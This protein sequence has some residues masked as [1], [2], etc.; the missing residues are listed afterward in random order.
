MKRILYLSFYFEPDLCAG[1]FRNSP[2]LKELALQTEGEAT[3]DVITTLP[4]RYSS[5]Q[6]DAT[7]FESVQNYTVRRIAIPQHQS[8]MKDQVLAFRHYY[9]K[10]HEFVKG[11]SYDLVFASSSRLFTAYLGYTI[12]KSRNIPLYLDIRDIFTDT[13]NDVLKNKFLKA[14]VLPVLKQIEKRVFQYASHINLISGGFKGYFE[15]YQGPA[16]SNFP[17]GIDEIFLNLPPSTVRHPGKK[18]IVYAGNFGE[19]QGLHIIVPQAAKRLES[20]YEFLLIGDG[21]AKDRLLKELT[22]LHVQN[23]NVMPPVKRSELLQIYQKSDFFFLHLNDYDAFKK[24]L[25]S[26]IFEMGASD[27]PIIAGVAGFAQEF[28]RTQVPNSIVFNPGDVNTMVSLLQNYTYQNI[29]RDEFKDKY[30]RENINREM[31]TSIRKYL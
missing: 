26:K 1:S 14:G 31:A 25:P 18:S 6:S 30:K 11:Q 7:A 17:N 22:R 23:V 29:P 15:Q 20:D 16:Y 9:A 4:N 10:V 5:F 3:I 28:L 19:G 21:G 24:V 2:L 13:L 12:A 8:G 27:K